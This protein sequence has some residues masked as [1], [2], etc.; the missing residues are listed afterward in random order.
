MHCPYCKDLSAKVR[1]HG[2]FKRRYNGQTYRVERFRCLKCRRTFSTQT[3]TLTYREHKAEVDETVF[4]LLCSGVSQR[5]SALLA[6]VN[7]KTIARKLVRPRHLCSQTSPSRGGSGRCRRDGS[8]RRNGDVRAQQMQAARRRR[9]G[10][11]RHAAH[12][13]CAGGCYAC[14]RQAGGPVATT[15]WQARRSRRAEALTHVLGEIRRASPHLTT[16]M[17]DKCPRYPTLVAKLLPGVRHVQTKGRRGCV[18][19]QGELK[20]GGKDPAVLPQSHLRYAARQPQDRESTNLV[21][22][23]KA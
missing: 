4:L 16:L 14:Q 1:H 21:H 18:V 17:S 5:R 9:C 22:S 19:G 12:Y 6:N 8:A 2:W 15:V 13:R 23:E 3:G 11:T 7:R 10:R 20:R